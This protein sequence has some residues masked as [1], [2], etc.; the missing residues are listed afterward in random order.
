V[1]LCRWKEDITARLCEELTLRQTS[2]WR[3]LLACQQ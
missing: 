3:T 2:L 1:S